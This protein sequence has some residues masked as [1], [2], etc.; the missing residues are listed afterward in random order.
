MPGY[1]KKPVSLG[2]AFLAVVIAQAKAQPVSIYQIQSNT[3]DGDQ[4]AYE[5]QVVDCTGGICVGR[6][7]GSR[8][9]LVLQNP[10][11]P[12]SWGG[13]QVKDWTNGDL[14][15]SVELGD[16]VEL[17]NVLVEEYRG[18]TFLQ[19]QTP[20]NPSFRIVSRDNSLPPPILVSVADIPAPLEH[21]AGE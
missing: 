18:T 16:W 4:S 19:Y 2:V 9:R 21:A 6:F 20:S 11:Y 1:G 10:A 13:I 7:V 8:P 12:D 14:F 3:T 15:D 5:H 17:S